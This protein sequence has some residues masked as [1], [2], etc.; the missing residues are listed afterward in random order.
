[1]REQQTRAA[2]RTDLNRLGVLSG[3]VVLMHSSYKALGPV[4]GG[5]ET[6]IAALIE[7]VG[8]TGT[9]LVPALSYMQEPR[10]VHD[11]RSTPSCIGAIA[12]YFRLRPGTRRSLHPTHSVCGIG[13]HA[14]MLLADH[15]LDKTPCGSHSPFQKMVDYDAKIIMLG[16]GLRPNTTMHSLE[17]LVEPPYLLTG[18]KFYEIT[19]GDGQTFNKNYCGHNF[20]GWGQRYDR[21]ADLSDT[22][23]MRCGPVL[24][25]ETHVI[26]TPGLRKAVTDQL[27]IDPFYFVEPIAS[28]S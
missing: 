17:E 25:A 13:H 14:D 21:V 12:E 16:C 19:D 23:F 15:L 27:K 24:A 4:A 20:D 5:I 2:I 18:E 8:D 9:L 28:D 6:V 3:D 7:T 10:H 11:T 1:M 26:E 22:R